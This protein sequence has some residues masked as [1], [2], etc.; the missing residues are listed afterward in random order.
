MQSNNVAKKT[1]MIMQMILL[2]FKYLYEWVQKII[3]DNLIQKI[4]NWNS[5]F[6]LIISI[7]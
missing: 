4:F 3:E 1:A 6:W 7:Y 5:F 2:I